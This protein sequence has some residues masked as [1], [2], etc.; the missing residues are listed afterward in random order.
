[1]GRGV[2]TFE[3]YDLRK[4]LGIRTFKS[5]MVREVKGKN[6]KPYEKSR[7]VVQDF[8]DNEKKE[9]LTQSPT[10]QRSGQRLLL[11]VAPSVIA[12]GMSLEL[13]DITQVPTSP[14][15]ARTYWLS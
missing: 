15:R 10:I 6:T 11:A 8:N 3:M 13:R 7:L 5:R 2:F 1:M 12:K 4:H 9:I 14:N